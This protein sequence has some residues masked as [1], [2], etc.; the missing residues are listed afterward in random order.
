MPERQEAFVIKADGRELNARAFDKRI[1]DQLLLDDDRE[2]IKLACEPNITSAVDS[3]GGLGLYRTK[4]IVEE[5]HGILGIRSG[6]AKAV[7]SPKKKFYAGGQD[8]WSS[9]NYF[10]RHRVYT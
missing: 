4:Q 1:I 10:Y 8:A 6:D 5:A 9:I 7:F 2:A 3:R